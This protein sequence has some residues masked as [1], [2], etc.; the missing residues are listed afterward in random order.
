MLAWWREL[1]EVPNHG[2]H[3]EFVQKVQTSFK[4]PKT[5]NYV[6]GV[7]NNHTP[8]LSHLSLEQYKFMP[9]LDLWFGSQDC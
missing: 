5:R 7:G 6:K 1:Q 3:W 9:P 8:L 4:V 2:D